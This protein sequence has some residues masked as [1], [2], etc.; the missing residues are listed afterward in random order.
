MPLDS[1]FTFDM[2]PAH[3]YHIEGD[4]LMTCNLLQTLLEKTNSSEEAVRDEAV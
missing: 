1:N 2:L 4:L 3:T